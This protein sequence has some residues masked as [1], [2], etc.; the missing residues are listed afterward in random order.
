MYEH[1]M[2]SPGHQSR[3]LSEDA[4]ALMSLWA[5]QRAHLAR[6]DTISPNA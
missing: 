5:R 2:T 1:Q 4:L 6:I 3:W